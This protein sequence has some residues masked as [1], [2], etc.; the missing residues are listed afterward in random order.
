MS[1]PHGAAIRWSAAEKPGRQPFL[2]PADQQGRL[3][4]GFWPQLNNS[5][6]TM[7]DEYEGD[8]IPPELARRMAAFTRE[9][10]ESERDDDVASLL[11]ALADFLD[12]GAANEQT[13]WA[14]F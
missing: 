8:A 11:R 5:L 14:D 2:I 3:F 1:T 9:Y 6:G 4:D 10:C 13:L 7:F 12:D